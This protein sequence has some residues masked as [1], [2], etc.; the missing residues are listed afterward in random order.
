MRTGLLRYFSPE[1]V[2]RGFSL[3][4][5]VL[6][7]AIQNKK[8]TA[9][10]AAAVFIVSP[11]INDLEQHIG[12]SF[13]VEPQPAARQPVPPDQQQLLMSSEVLTVGTGP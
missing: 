12:F 10:N 11:A 9:V 5:A 2:S 8:T 13:T 7:P 3:P 1:M 6:Q 4:G